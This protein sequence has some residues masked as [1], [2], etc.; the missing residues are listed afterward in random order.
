MKWI[1][2]A[3]HVRAQWHRLSRA[4][5]FTFRKLGQD[6]IRLTGNRTHRDAAKRTGSRCWKNLGCACDHSRGEVFCGERRRVEIAR[7]IAMEPA[8]LLLD[9]PFTGI[10][11]IAVPIFR[12]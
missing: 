7:A 8:F 2:L 9:E 1:F 10:D 12:R 3:A 4:G 5:E 11:P 6:N